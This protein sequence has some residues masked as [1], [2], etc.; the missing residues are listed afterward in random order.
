MSY[1]LCNNFI[2]YMWREVWRFRLL[3]INIFVR[4]SNALFAISI[5]A[6]MWYCRNVLLLPC[7]LSVW[8]W[9]NLLLS[10]FDD[11]LLVVRAMFGGLCSVIGLWMSEG[12]VTCCRELYNWKSYSHGFSCLFTLDVF[13]RSLNFAC[14][15]WWAPSVAERVVKS[16]LPFFGEI[17]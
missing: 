16:S 9:V 15:S 11:V 12:L 17:M 4:H 14:S 8:V 6:I 1:F 7:A 5:I 10:T 2:L 3:K 13:P